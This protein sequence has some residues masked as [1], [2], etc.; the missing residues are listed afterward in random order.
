M[1]WD[2]HEEVTHFVGGIPI[3]MD[4]PPK[5]GETA[6]LTTGG[7]EFDV[8]ISEIDD[9]RISGEVVRIGPDA[10][11]NAADIKRGDVVFFHVEHIHTLYRTRDGA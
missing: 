5:V 7:F 3:D 4:A 9:G 8:E 2:R 10:L 1:I 6:R 11:L